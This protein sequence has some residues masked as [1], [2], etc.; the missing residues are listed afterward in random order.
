M[1]LITDAI[2]TQHITGFTRNAQC[3]HA[4]VTLHHGDH[5]RWELSAHRVLLAT[6]LWTRGSN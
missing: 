4:R 1:V 3:L 2:A 5:L 6:N